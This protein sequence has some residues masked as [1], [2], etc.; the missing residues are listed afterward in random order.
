[1]TGIQVRPGSRYCRGDGDTQP[2]Q[3]NVSCDG[4]L[5]TGIQVRQD[6]GTLG[7]M[8]TLNL[9]VENQLDDGKNEEEM[10]LQ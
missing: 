2:G 5:V 1:M 8:G 7:V 9:E 10:V 6:P 4:A 3:D